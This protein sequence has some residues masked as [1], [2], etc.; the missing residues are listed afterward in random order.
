LP[1]DQLSDPVFTV[2]ASATFNWR[3]FELG[4]EVTNLFDNRYRLGEYNYASDFHSA[5]QPTLVPMR[6][7]SAGPPRMFFM[8]FAIS[9]GEQ[10]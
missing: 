10:S 1:Y 2:D 4:F 9:F 7:F 8:T 6:H 3:R 5:E